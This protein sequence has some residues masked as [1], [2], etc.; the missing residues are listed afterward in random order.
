[1]CGILILILLGLLYM[2]YRKALYDSE[3]EH[4]NPVTQRPKFD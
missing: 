3:R 4:G 1:M 2:F